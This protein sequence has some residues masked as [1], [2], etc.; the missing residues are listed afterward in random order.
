MRVD[1]KKLEVSTKTWGGRGGRCVSVRVN[2]STNVE[3]Y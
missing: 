1:G 2:V 3:V